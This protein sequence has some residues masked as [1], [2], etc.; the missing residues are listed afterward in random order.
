MNKKDEEKL[1]E[2]ILNICDKSMDF[3]HKNTENTI[4]F[5][6]HQYYDLLI[7]LNDIYNKE[8]NKLFKKKYKEWEKEIKNKN[9]QIKKVLENISKEFKKNY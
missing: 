3:I 5:Y 1:T 6:K 8:P 7:E 2:V 4:D 9:E